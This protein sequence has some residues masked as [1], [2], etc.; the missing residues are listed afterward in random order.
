MV[1]SISNHCTEIIVLLLGANRVLSTSPNSIHSLLSAYF[2][3]HSTSE[4][5]Y[6]SVALTEHPA[7]HITAASFWAVLAIGLSCRF[8]PFF[9]SQVFVGSLVGSL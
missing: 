9:V 7:F 1:R 4:A 8:I 2:L 3:L 6:N 5:S